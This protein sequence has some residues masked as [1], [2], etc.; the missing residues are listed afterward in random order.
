MG[1]LTN[2]NGVGV[3]HTTDRPPRDECLTNFVL[4]RVRRRFVSH[5][6]FLTGQ[7]TPPRH[8]ASVLVQLVVEGK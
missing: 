2:F 3:V 5:E 7:P 6:S 8:K 4:S 1:G